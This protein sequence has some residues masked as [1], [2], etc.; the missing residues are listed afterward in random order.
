[1]GEDLENQW[2]G[3]TSEEGCFCQVQFRSEEGWEALTRGAVVYLYIFRTTCGHFIAMAG[4]IASSMQPVSYESNQFDL[5]Q[6]LEW[7][8]YDLSCSLKQL[9]D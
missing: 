2:L 5:Q 6:W 3:E 4:L 7:G 9:A 8:Q 1:M